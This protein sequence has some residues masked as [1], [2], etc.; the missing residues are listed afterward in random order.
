[1]QKNGN[2]LEN[3]YC[4]LKK[5]IDKELTQ[6]L[7]SYLLQKKKVFITYRTI[8]RISPFNLDWGAQ[9]DKMIPTTYNIYGDTAMDNLLHILKDKIENVTQHKLK[10]SYSYARLY[11]RGDY[12]KKHSDR[13]SCRI[14]VTLNLGGELWPFY[15]IDKKN[16]LVK[17]LL[18]P[19]DCLVYLGTE[20]VHWRDPFEGD[21]CGQVFLHYNLKNEK[22]KPYDG[23]LHL[24]LPFKDKKDD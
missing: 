10:E 15:I 22:K 21:S 4:H 6:F 14:S 18:K 7:Y 5:I 3:G 1:M 20:L 16:I 2:F 24:G 19:G 11:E 23:R 12:L 9:G 8:K 13:N 17:A